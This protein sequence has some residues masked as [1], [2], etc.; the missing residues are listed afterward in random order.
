[1]KK[2]VLLILLAAATFSFTSC[3]SDDD[4]TTTGD[5]KATWDLVA[6][7]P[8]LFDLE[9]CPNNPTITFNENNTTEW[10][11]YNAD[12]DCQAETDS[13]EWTGDGND[14][15]VS[16]PGYGSFDGT[17]EFQSEDEFSFTSSYN[18]LQ[19]VLYFEK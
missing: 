2:H 15:S 18:G 16:I 5:I 4:G 12:N 13:G 6:S 10:T 19:V 17:V 7:Q 9:E 14:Y 3:S 1:M 8:P 11:F